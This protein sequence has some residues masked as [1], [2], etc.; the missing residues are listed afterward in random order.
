MP[1]LQLRV[2]ISL[3][4]TFVLILTTVSLWKKEPVPPLWSQKY[5][6][7]FKHLR[8]GQIDAA[9]SL[10]RE[11]VADPENKLGFGL[12]G[13][14]VIAFEEGRVSEA[15]EDLRKA[16]AANPA[17]VMALLVQGDLAFSMG[18]RERAVNAY[19]QA[20]QQDTQWAWQKALA[21]NAL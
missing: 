16:L 12:D 21:Y 15:K 13:F 9:D 2:V 4:V 19:L 1:R 18:E 11:A 20:T 14:A 10:L 3:S 7:A 8:T 5:E 17:N 6:Q